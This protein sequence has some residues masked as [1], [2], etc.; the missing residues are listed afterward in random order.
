MPR[1]LR[2]QRDLKRRIESGA[3]P[4]G[5]GLPSQRQLSR[6]YRVTLMTLRHALELLR[7]EGL[8]VTRQGRGTRVA[9]RRVAYS[10][11][12][13]HSLSQE[14]AQRGLP[15]TTR[16][17]ASA[18]E[19]A[20]A[21]V[22]HALDLRLGV[23]VLRLDRLRNIAGQVSVYQHSYLPATIGRR[24]L[25]HDL[26]LRSLYEVLAVDL[27]LPVQ[28]ATEEIR[29]ILL[30]GEEARLLQAEPRAAAMLSARTTFTRGMRPMLYDQ[31]YLPGDRFMIT[32][33]RQSDE[34][35]VR[36]ELRTPEEVE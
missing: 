29:P 4:P 10:I 21:P 25:E 1:Y 28:R 23:H 9:P 17:L 26:A 2:I 15:V 8:I 5:S 12:T 24:V 20:S 31:A 16:V 7:Q 35:A 36:Y 11:G 19:A 34:V 27:G 32:T 33:T 22:A 3:L 14:M 30:G 18:F 13:L 6:E